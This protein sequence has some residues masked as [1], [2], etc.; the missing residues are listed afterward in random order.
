MSSVFH[1]FCE[2]RVLIFFFFVGIQFFFLGVVSYVF[3]TMGL[4]I[5]II[6]F[7][8]REF[9]KTCILVKIMLFTIVSDGSSHLF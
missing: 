3:V 6:Y 9:E 2:V 1:T 8:I 4:F 7:F 5:H